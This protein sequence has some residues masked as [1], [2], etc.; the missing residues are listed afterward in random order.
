MHKIL[1]SFLFF[2]IFSVHTLDLKASHDIFPGG[3]R[4]VS[5]GGAAVTNSDLWSAFNNQAGLAA[6]ESVTA[7]LA[8]ENQFLLKELGVKAGA[9]AVPVN[10]GVFA[11][12]L[13]QYGFNLYNENKVGL[14]YAMNLNENLSAGVQ[15]DYLL[16]QI[17]E[18][19][20]RKGVFTFE[21]GLMA[22][23]SEN[24]SLG[25]HI[26]NPINVKITDYV[27]E[28]I[29]AIVK[30]GMRYTFSDVALMVAEI[31]KDINHT[32]VVRFGVEY[33]I[34]EN[35]Y[36]RTGVASNPSL[37]SFGFGLNFRNF[38]LD[39]GTSK[40]NV[41]GYTPALSLMYNF[42]TFN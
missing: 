16:T 26:F 13:S 11:L 28:R 27:E 23:L 8:Y 30:F 21:I 33:Q 20:G 10:S 32:A 1:L 22:K 9:V 37:F 24:I 5:M 7:G 3:G 4:A 12:S 14:A 34:V 15:L 25:G 18:D 36:V 42:N 41:L 2:C 6:L 40:H 39:F 38:K 19:Y 35:I 17:A 31:E 29:P